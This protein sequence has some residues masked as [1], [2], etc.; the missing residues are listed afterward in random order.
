MVFK[1]LA[2]VMRQVENC[3]HKALWAYVAVDT[4]LRILIVDERIR[5]ADNGGLSRILERFCVAE[6]ISIMVHF[7]RY[8]PQR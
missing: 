3:G 8:E 6:D 4:G 7:P 1:P 2:R 5:Y